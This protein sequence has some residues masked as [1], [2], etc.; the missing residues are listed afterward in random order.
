[1]AGRRL[2]LGVADLGLMTDDAHHMSLI[3]LIINGVAHRLAVYGETLIFSSV[4]LIPALQRLVQILRV[5]ADKNI[6]DD[7]FAGYNVSAILAAAAETIPGFLAK[8][9]GPIR[10]RFVSAHPAQDCPGRYGQNSIQ[11]MP[12]SLGAALIGNAF[13][14]G[15]KGL[16][17]ICVE[18]DFGISLT[19]GSGKNRAG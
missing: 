7:G 18:H 2:F 9:I 1:M 13:E 3:A 17:L 11:S 6:P 19:I 4:N 10:D 5:D 16:H 12:P 8:T 14:E 15:R